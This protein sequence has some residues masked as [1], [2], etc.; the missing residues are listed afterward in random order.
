MNEVLDV[1]LLRRPMLYYV[2]PPVCP[3]TMSGS[4]SGIMFEAV[5]GP[6][7]PTG[8]RLEGQC[9]R[10]VVWDPYPNLVA[11]SLY[12]VPDSSQMFGGYLSLVDGVPLWAVSVSS[13]GWWRATSVTY[14]GVESA[15]GETVLSPGGGWVSVPVPFVIGPAKI[16][17]YKNPDP[18]NKAGTYE[19]VLSTASNGAIEIGDP[20]GCYRLQAITADG[21]SELSTPVCRDALLNCCPPVPCAD[22]YSW[23]STQCSCTAGTLG[24]MGPDEKYCVGVAYASQFTAVGGAAPYN[25]E[26]ISGTPPPGLTF[27]TGLFLG[28]TAPID[29][30]PTVAG[31]YTFTIKVTESGGL[32]A[33][34]AVTI[35][36]MGVNESL[37]GVTDTA[38]SQQLTTGGGVAP[39]VFSVVAGAL[40][41]GLSMTAAGLI[42]GTPLIISANTLTIR[43]T[44]LLGAYCDTVLSFPIVGC[45]VVTSYPTITWASL[46]GSGAMGQQNAVLDTAR[47]MLWIK[48][49]GFGGAWISL[50]SVTGVSTSSNAYVAEYMGSWGGPGGSQ[51][52]FAALAMAYDSV[53]DVVVILAQA[54]GWE[55][56]DPATG[57]FSSTAPTS[58][59]LTP[60]TNYRLAYDS[61]RGNCLATD[62]F[63]GGGRFEVTN[64]TKTT[65]SVV[66]ASP[67]LGGLIGQPTYSE[68]IDRFVIQR[69]GSNPPLYYVHPV[70]FA[71]TLS[72]VNDTAG[73][74]SPTNKL[75]NLPGTPYV[76]FINSGGK[77]VFVNVLTDT[78]YYT[79]AESMAGGYVAD[80]AYNSCTG[81]FYVADGPTQVQGFS[82]A[83]KARVHLSA[84]TYTSLVFDPAAG[85]VYAVV[86]GTTANPVIDTL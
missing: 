83:L 21:A 63:G 37:S 12:G 8:V 84:G 72:T 17:L 66:Y 33:T 76:A 28:T 35:S 82:L 13:P 4:G 51:L 80:A 70:T 55:K 67:A 56:F 65:F 19:L 71:L 48:R 57:V 38:Y 77:V 45:P 5:Y 79:T 59:L 7:P 68:A 73:G 26:L 23:D 24:T 6:T 78:V 39:Y 16:N 22:L 30:T 86:P 53:N 75:W 1:I 14:E 34:Q 27:H 52:P 43:V 81:V 69:Q 11:M 47:R 25:W 50:D 40:P 49:D 9:N 46:Y 44:D 60:Q 32:T 61:T 31:S 3:V 58:T 36:G 18:T 62:M 74:S 42:T 15:P 41:Y 20:T 10:F 29:G 2:S 64:T 54:H 85:K